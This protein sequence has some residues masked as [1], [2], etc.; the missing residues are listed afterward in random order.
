MN[1]YSIK[2]D[3]YRIRETYLEWIKQFLIDRT[4]QVI[5][6]NKL[7][8]SIPVFSG[9]PQESVL[10]ALLFLLYI[11]D[12]PCNTNS[13]VKLYADDI[14][15]YKRI[16]DPS[17]YHALQNDLNKLAHWSTIWLMPF[18]LTPSTCEHLIA[19]NKPSPFLYNYR[20][21]DYMIQRIQSTKYL[22]LTISGN[23]S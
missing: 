17:D 13:V 14:L 21:N 5:I 10:G 19:T 23:L 16:N 8:D 22:G 20:L 1:D 12:L 15:M 9:V 7:S 2:L 3:Y 18:N 11:N 6:E 4:Q